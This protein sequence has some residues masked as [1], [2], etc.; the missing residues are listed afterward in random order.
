MASRTLLAILML[1]LFAASLL[2]APVGAGQEEAGEWKIIALPFFGQLNVTGNYSA[3]LAVVI[4]YGRMEVAIDLNHNGVVDPDEPYFNESYP[5]KLTLVISY[6]FSFGDVE[7]AG[8]MGA[9]WILTKTP[10]AVEVLVDDGRGYALAYDMPP[11]GT[12]FL[13]P[14]G[15]PGDVYITPAT[16]AGARVNVTGDDVN[17]TAALDPGEVLVV[18]TNGTEAWIESDAPVTAVLVGV[19]NN[20]MYAAELVPHDEAFFVN[21]SPMPI[22]MGMYNGTGLGLAETQILAV[23]PTGYTFWTPSTTVDSMSESIPGF[24]EGYYYVY[25]RTEGGGEGLTPVYNLSWW[26]NYFNDEIKYWLVT[27]TLYPGPDSYASLEVINY[28]IMRLANI[29]LRM[30]DPRDKTTFMEAL[31]DIS[32]QRP[33]IMKTSEST[34]WVNLVI[35]GHA[36]TILIYRNIGLE[37]GG[38]PILRTLAIPVPSS[39]VQTLREGFLQAPGT[40]HD[41]SKTRFWRAVGGIS[42][43]TSQTG[44]TGVFSPDIRVEINEDECA[45]SNATVM[46]LTEDLYV[47]GINWTTPDRCEADL[48]IDYESNSSLVFYYLILVDTPIGPAS[49]VGE[50]YLAGFIVDAPPTPP[51]IGPVS[52]AQEGVIEPGVVAAT[53]YYG[54]SKGGLLGPA[55]SPGYIIETLLDR[56][57]PGL[58]IAAPPGP[59]P[60]GG[61]TGTET[62]TTQ[63]GETATTTP[64]ETT[65][66]PVTETPT[67]TTQREETTTTTT[68]PT[69]TAQETGGESPARTTPPPGETETG[70]EEGFP[71]LLI[72]AVIVV[73]LVAVIAVAVFFLRR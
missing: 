26:S 56:T 58:P 21:D 65:T 23:Y 43:S 24:N 57:P 2:Q 25:I 16:T 47:A 4:A 35:R 60:V 61:G 18:N 46:I 8:D 7:L 72:A 41:W 1:G 71:I 40:F 27:Y 64:G 32:V 10:I 70:G 49:P 51:A 66:P 34:L 11:P 48:G 55:P 3:Y 67:T 20:S 28:D 52:H 68:T 13:V 14:P 37:E 53:V 5:G 38:D 45:V 59:P 19:G 44:T 42:M 22:P 33:F 63:P 54:P 9:L 12:R 50:Y 73:I 69:T 15:I 31:F 39:E 29:Y 36:T 17:I 62:T 30:G 6:G